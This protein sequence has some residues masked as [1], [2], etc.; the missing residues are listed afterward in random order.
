MMKKNMNKIIL[1]SAIV[2]FPIIIGLL[3]W[4]KLPEQIATHWGANGVADGWSS[5]AYAVF[6]LP[7]FIL[8]AHLFCV[9]VCFSDPKVKDQGRKVLWLVLGLCPAVSILCSA[10]V[11]I[12]ALDIKIPIEKIVPASLGLLFAVLGNYLPKCKQSYTIGFKLPWTLSNEE[13]WNKTHRLAGKLWVIGGLILMSLIL[14]PKSLIVIIIPLT[15]TLMILVPLFYSYAL[16]QRQTKHDGDGR[17]QP[18]SGSSMSKWNSLIITLSV[19]FGI[20]LCIGVGVLLFSGDISVQY[21]DSSF[22][23]KATYWS[24]LEVDYNAIEN[25]EFRQTNDA[26]QRTNGFGSSRLLMGTFRNDE[27]GTY[28]RYSYTKCPSAVVMTVSGK[29]LVLSGAD[30]DSTQAIYHEL[31]SRIKQ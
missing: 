28:T 31:L 30:D 7:C 11:Y 19:I 24:D 9:F 17:I 16:Y 13:N 5:K 18:P 2:L 29:T 27:F 26:G 22:T 12:T 8:I 25:I 20:M 1:S 6:A 23:I 14:L 4:N 21:G 3:I 10:F 15:F